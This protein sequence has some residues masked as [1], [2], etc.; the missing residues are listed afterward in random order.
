MKFV[1][2]LMQERKGFKSLKAK[3]L[4]HWSEEI[5]NISL[6]YRDV[7]EFTS[8]VNR[9]HSAQLL[10]LFG[11]GFYTILLESFYMYYNV[12]KL[13]ENSALTS[14]YSDI[15][16]NCLLIVFYS[17]EMLYIVLVSKLVMIHIELLSLQS[18]SFHSISFC[19]LALIDSKL[20]LQ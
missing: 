6:V 18:L 2:E 7:S 11:T 5:D 8:K 3:Y 16:K 13:R 20:L 19:G 9:I 14:L 10:F 4:S 12:K 1:I 15:F 17:L